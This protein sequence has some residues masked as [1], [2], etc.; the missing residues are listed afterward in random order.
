MEAKKQ[1]WYNVLLFSLFMTGTSSAYCDVSKTKSML[2]GNNLT[3]KPL[4]DLSISSSDFSSMSYTLSD[5]SAFSVSLSNRVYTLQALKTG[6]Y[7]FKVSVTWKGVGSYNSYKTDYATYTIK[8]TSQVLV[9]KISINTTEAEIKEGGQVQLT[10]TVSPSNA[11]N[12]SVQWRSSNESVATVG[13]NGLVTGVGVGTCNIIVS[14]TDGSNLSVSCLVRVTS[15]VVLVSSIGLNYNNYE[16]MEGKQVQLTAT[17]SPSNATNKSVQWKSSNESIATVGTNGLVTG[18]SVGTCNIIVSTTDGSNLSASCL[19]RVTS[20]NVLVS[21]VVLN[22]TY[23]ELMAGEK[24]QLVANVSPSNATNGFINWTSNNSAFAIVDEKGLVTAVAPGLCNITATTVDGSNK[25]ASCQINVLSNVLYTEDAIGVP[26]G[27]LV[28]PIYMR[29]ALSITGLQFE[30][31]LPEGVSV[32]EN[33]NGKPTITLSDRAADQTIASSILSNGNYQFVVFS[34]SSTALNGNEGAIAY[35]TLNVGADVAVGE[36]SIGI[37][38][39]E[40]TTTNSVSLHHKDLTSKLIVAEATLGDTNGD[41]RVTV[42]DAVSIVNYIL[43]RVPSV[44]ISKAADVNGDGNITITD[45]VNIINQ[46]LN[47]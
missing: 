20:S 47:Q 37:K 29:N 35:V 16:I 19:I 45:A 17:V 27:T 33:G 6:T 26:S 18:V 21:S 13:A 2:L 38:E 36:Y 23:Y 34:P 8:V 11:T 3:I 24:L 15:S 9:T 14:T 30:L 41:G 7:T 46:I 1:I 43:E 22:Y 44:F 31:E 32:T 25:S 39:V 12:K 28:L 5:K 40:L 42:T 4:A 10:A